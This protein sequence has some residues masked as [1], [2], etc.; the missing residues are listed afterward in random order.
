MAE[1]SEIEIVISSEGEVR[2]HA[3][4]MKGPVCEKVVRKIG[5]DIGELKEFVRSSEYYEKT[6]TDA[7]VKPKVGR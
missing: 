3:R 6:T 7:S 4:G 1:K 5:A 2:V